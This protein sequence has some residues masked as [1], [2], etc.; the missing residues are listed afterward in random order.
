MSIADRKYESSWIGRSLT[1]YKAI[2][3][4]KAKKKGVQDAFEAA[5]T[6]T[7]ARKILFGVKKGNDR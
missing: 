2:H 6:L 7:Q 4:D 1:N 3:A 5:K